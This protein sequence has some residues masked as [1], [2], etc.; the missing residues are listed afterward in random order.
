MQIRIF[1]TICILLF[2]VVSLSR[3]SFAPSTSICKADRDFFRIGEP[4]L[5]RSVG[6]DENLDISMAFEKMEYLNV[7]R[8]RE[9]VW[10]YLIFKENNTGLNQTGVN[11]LNEIIMEAQS[12]NITVL[13]MVQ[14]FPNWM[15]GIGDVYCIQQFVPDRDLA[16]GSPYD[17]F[18]KEYTQ[19]W[20]DLVGT[21][22]N[23]T[24][25]EIGNEYNLDEF[26][27]PKDYPDKNF[28]ID[29]KVEITMDLLYF[30]SKA[31][32]ETNPKATTVLG[33]LGGLDDLTNI[34][35][36]LNMLYERIEN[37]AYHPYTNST[38][39]D[40]FFHVVSWHPYLSTNPPNQTWINQNE[41][42]HNV[43]VAHGDEGKPVIFSEFGYSDNSTGLDETQVA[44]RL[45]DTYKLA[46]DFSWLDAIYWY[47]LIDWNS[48]YDN[49]PPKQCGFGLVTKYFEVKEAG[50]AYRVIDEF[51]VPF[52]LITMIVLTASAV[53]LP[54]TLRRG[55]R[56][57][58]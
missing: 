15:T 55:A 53:V 29:E 21:F 27:H 44:E 33:G 35:T 24:E 12:H 13:G 28:T 10:R 32:N 43:M 25:W 17:I 2:S 23:I 26:L 46:Q 50:E 57:K 34:S 4:L 52:L 31:I 41:V 6:T 39:P 5:W 36:F 11:K 49:F 1:S 56:A 45:N 30:G 14:D 58:T 9:W 16:E 38:D 7:C 47:K 18:L 8:L 42:I 19:S 40:D 51:S 22:P 48:L 54:K 20:R 3:V 37:I